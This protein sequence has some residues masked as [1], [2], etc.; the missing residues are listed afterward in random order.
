[1]S[2]KTETTGLETAGLKTL[3]LLRRI[4]ASC[5][6]RTEGLSFLLT[7]VHND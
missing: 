1:M 2:L 5:G 3:P 4:R 7:L 6:L